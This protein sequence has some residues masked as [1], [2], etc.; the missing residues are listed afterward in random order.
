[1]LTGRRKWASVFLTG[2]AEAEHT[3]DNDAQL[4]TADRNPAQP[5]PAAAPATHAATHKDAPSQRKLEARGGT[6]FVA[7]PAGLEAGN[8]RQL[9]QPVLDAKAMAKQEIG[10]SNEGQDVG[11]TQAAAE[12]R[13]S[14]HPELLF[15]AGRVFWLIPPHE[16]PGASIPASVPSAE[17]CMLQVAVCLCEL[18]S[19][20]VTLWWSAV[21]KT[22]IEQAHIVASYAAILLVPS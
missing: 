9:P 16:A 19:N 20:E 3:V 21:H 10:K 22:C 8:T 17:V 4:Q 18:L 11:P 14:E 2:A 15:C 1:M 6:P 7:P 5:H 12:Q 13:A